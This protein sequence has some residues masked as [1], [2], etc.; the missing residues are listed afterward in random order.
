MSKNMFH[1]PVNGYKKCIINHCENYTHD[2]ICFDCW[3]KHDKAIKVFEEAEKIKKT[4]ER[5]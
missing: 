2:I 1:V 3:C 5:K 4:N